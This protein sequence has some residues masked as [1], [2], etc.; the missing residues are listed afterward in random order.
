MEWENVISRR[1]KEN[2]QGKEKLKIDFAVIKISALR[3][4]EN[5][6]T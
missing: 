1:K 4:L 5:V 6:L 2:A 3:Y